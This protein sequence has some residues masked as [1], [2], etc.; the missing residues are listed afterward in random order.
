LAAS[1]QQR[2]LPSTPVLGL[3]ALATLS[4]DRARVA[5]PPD[6]MQGKKVADNNAGA[7]MGESNIK[8]KR[9]YRQYMNRPSECAEELRGGV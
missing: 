7:A 4:C 3:A 6:Y 1:N 5:H 9:T 2:S 8:T